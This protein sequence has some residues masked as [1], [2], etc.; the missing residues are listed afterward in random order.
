MDKKTEKIFH[1]ELKIPCHIN[2]IADRIFKTTREETQ[3]IINELVLRGIVERSH[4]AKEYY[5]IKENV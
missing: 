3:F 5:K 1:K 2:Y 4:L